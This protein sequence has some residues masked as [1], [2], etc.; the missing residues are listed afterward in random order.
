M[1]TV[2]S[3]YFMTG[4]FINMFEKKKLSENGHHKPRGE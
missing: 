2:M 4:L 3:V 1:Q